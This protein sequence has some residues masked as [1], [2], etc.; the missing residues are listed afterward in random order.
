MRK[1]KDPLV[2]YKKNTK[3]RSLKLAMS[4]S[5]LAGVVA[6]SAFTEAVQA[7]EIE[8]NQEEI[9]EL[10][11]QY[12]DLQS[13][14]NEEGSVDAETNSE[15]VSEV[16]E[17]TDE[18]KE[19]LEFVKTQLITMIELAG[20]ESLLEQ[21]NVENLSSDDLNTVFEALLTYQLEQKENSEI[22]ES[23]VQE[24]ETTISDEALNNIEDQEAITEEAEIST[25]ET[26]TE[27]SIIM[28]NSDQVTD[29]LNESVELVQTES[30]EETL[31]E[32]G[33]SESAQ[34]E[35]TI[36]EETAEVE[37]Q[38]EL[39]E[40][41]TEEANPESDIELEEDQ[42]TEIV[43]E[44]VEEQEEQQEQQVV[45]KVEVKPTEQPK[46]E[47]APEVK[48]ETKTPTKAITHTV[49]SGDTLNKIAK[50]YNTTVS[51]IVSL[52]KLS[53]ANYIKVGQKL[54]INKTAVS[55]V[56]QA[57]TGNLNQAQ[58]SNQFINQIAAYAQKVAKENGVFASIMIAQASLESG[59]GKSQ[60]AAPPNHNLFGIKGSYNGN[61]VAMKTKEYYKSTGW[62]T[63][64]D[65]FKKYPSYAESLQDNARLIRSGTS[66]NSE[67]YSGAWVENAN[68][69]KDASAWLQGRYATD[70][71]YASKL[72]KIIE[73]YGLTRYDSIGNGG[74]NT[75]NTEDSNEVITN[76]TKPVT[77]PSAGNTESDKSGK[78]YVVI[79]G[80]TLTAIARRNGTTVSKIKAANNLKSDMIYVNQTLTIP[81]SSSSVPTQNDSNT[82]N[83]DSSQESNKTSYTVKSGDTLTAIARS[84]KTTV[85]AI[86]A[87]NNLKSDLIFV[88]QKLIVAGTPSNGST[89]NTNSNSD[90]NKTTYSIVGGDTLTAIAKR[91]NTT[92][93]AIKAANNLK[94]DLIFVGQKLTIS[95]KASNES[96][97]D[98]AQ[99]TVESSYTVVSGDTLT[100]IARKYKTTVSAIKTTNK[101]KSDLIFVN[102]KLVVNGKVENNA[103]STPVK[104]DQNQ[105]TKKTSY[106]VVSGDTLT[107]IAR[108]YSTSVSA[109]KSLNNLKTDL[110]FANQKLVVTGTN[111]ET[112]SSTDKTETENQSVTTGTYKVV[113]GDTLSGLARRYKTTIAKIKTD[114]KLSS[115]MIYV[116][117]S[118]LLNGQKT[119]TVT[120]ETKAPVSQEKETKSTITVVSGDTLSGL[121]R[122][123]NTTIAKLQE[124]NNLKS[125]LIYVG[126]KLSV[127]STTSS[128]TVI[129]SKSVTEKPEQVEKQTTTGNY[130]VLSGDSLFKIALDN[131]TT[132]AELKKLNQLSSDTIYIGQ[133]LLIGKDTKVVTEEKEAS[134]EGYQVKSGDTLSEIARNL[135]TTVQ[136]LKEKNQLSTDTIY[137]GQTLAV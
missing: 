34:E 131:D 108:K 79:S 124:A 48:E 129:S 2:T 25:D 40:N 77:T 50:Q 123:Y 17:L 45:E 90:T 119:A 66:W 95:G 68:S 42:E 27:E 121:A 118:L 116:G 38:K 21:L 4:S 49:K 23:L 136:A 104:T 89:D 43:E 62:I 85:S 54:A 117:Q 91:Y 71:T 35:A 61:S 18:E 52:N 93:S 96:S 133:K 81:G 114:N 64:T 69:Y 29:E 103:E 51:N 97:R 87:A 24:N 33:N 12:N 102:Q 20:G 135:N 31:V 30:G 28:Q 80:D 125:D 11:D 10:Y 16:E 132:V 98:D 15:T 137:I 122:K 86:K 8:L 74:S 109:I 73:I 130:T 113:A 56:P 53:N 127:V 88:N 37:D 70:P 107:S 65:Y 39:S 94:S 76:P 44:K 83:P 58:T 55:T 9:Q 32:E 128:S 57:G 72:N 60:L 26:Y 84:Y 99:S 106:T 5:V 82:T 19:E 111:S 13:S 112:S 22:A 120:E 47:T 134:L 3:R 75:G 110:I 36:T 100:S 7:E 63:I 1:Q 6:V 14:F 105:S 115:D 67:Y 126:Q 78:Q 46:V 41:V 59:Y 101:L 92:V